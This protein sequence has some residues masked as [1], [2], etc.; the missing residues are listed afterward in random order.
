MKK[1]EFFKELIDTDIFEEV[2]D[3]LVNLTKFIGDRENEKALDRKINRNL[4]SYR[5]SCF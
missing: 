4:R 2:Y 1:L 3:V 5:C